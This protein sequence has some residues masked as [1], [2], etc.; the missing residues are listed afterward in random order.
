MRERTPSA[1]SWEALPF[2][3]ARASCFS[4]FPIPPS[5][6]AWSTSRTTTSHPAWAQICVIP[7]PIR[8]QPTTPTLLI[9]MREPLLRRVDCS[10]DRG[11][12]HGWDE[13]HAV[14]DLDRPAA[15]LA[16][17]SRAVGL[18]SERLVER[19]RP[20]RVPEGPQRRLGERR[21]GQPL[22][23]VGD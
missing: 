23:C 9:S 11:S 8:P 19:A 20:G 1:S 21:S 17:L 13:G 10:E 2:S 18:E 5:S 7:W 16:P 6:F 14:A 15:R 3:T 12:L 4:I 22:Q